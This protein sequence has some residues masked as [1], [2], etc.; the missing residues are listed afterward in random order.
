MK[1]LKQRAVEYSPYLAAVAANVPL[2]ATGLYL[3]SYDA[4]TH[5]FFAD[6]Y[7]RAWFNLWDT[8]WYGGFSLAGY[9]PLSHQIMALLSFST[10]LDFSFGILLIASILF[11]IWATW[12][13]AGAFGLRSSSLPWLVAFSPGLFLFMYVFGQLPGVLATAFMF[14]SSAYLG[15]YLKDGRMR[16]L[17]LAVLLSALSFFTHYVTFIFLSPLP[18]VVLLTASPDKMGIKRMAAWALLSVALMLPVAL[19]VLGFMQATPAQ[20]PIP[21]PSREDVLVGPY[22]GP[23]FWGIYGPV[24]AL[25]PLSFFTIYETKK[26]ALGALTAAYIVLGLGGSTPIPRLVF[27]ALYDTLTFEKFTLW[28]CLLLIV[29]LGYYLEYRLP[30]DYGKLAK[31]LKYAVVLSMVAVS[32]LVLY[33]SNVVLHQPPAPDV[34]AVASYLNSQHGDGFYITLGL[35]TWSRELSIISAHPTLDGGFNTARRIPLLAQSGAETIDSAKY[36]KGGMQLVGSILTGNYGVRWVVLGDE[37]YRPYLVDSGFVEVQ[38]VNGALPVS[39]WERGGYEDGYRMTMV[40]INETSYLW[41]LL[42]P[43]ALIATLILALKK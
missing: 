8:R 38:Q 3:G 17:G 34:P 29:P 4:F 5:L 18:L 7:R 11:L 6:H 27:G 15:K 19:Q 37:T 20:A 16:E 22:S 30:H 24:I 23:Y 36:Y 31:G 12:R 28:A 42:P 26:W 25:A 9:T 33:A 14:A 39:I 41:G 13:L 2:V 10:G 21:H 43:L 35:G 40:D 1:L 32:G